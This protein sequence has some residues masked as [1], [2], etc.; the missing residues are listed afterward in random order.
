MYSM[1]A[2][3]DSLHDMCDCQQ[4]NIVAKGAVIEPT[5]VYSTSKS[6]MAHKQHNW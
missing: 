1:D 4:I 5:S 2:T 3:L 6:D